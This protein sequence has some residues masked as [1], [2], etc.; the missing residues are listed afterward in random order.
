MANQEVAIAVRCS[1]PMKYLVYQVVGRGDILL[2]RAVDVSSP[3]K[4]LCH[5]E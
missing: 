2:S 3:L 5:M 4:V 1:E